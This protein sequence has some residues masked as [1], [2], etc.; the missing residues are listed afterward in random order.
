MTSDNEIDAL[1]LGAYVDGELDPAHTARV[2]AWL[3]LHPEGQARVTAWQQQNVA[4][5]AALDPLLDAPVPRRLTQASSG[6]PRKSI[7]TRWVALRVAAALVLMASGIAVGW[8]LRSPE[9]LGASGGSVIARALDAHVI[10]AAETRHPVEVTSSE[11]DH[12]NA[13][14]S[15]RLGHPIK[16]PDLSPA[17]YRL[18]G[19]R[20]LS[21]GGR[22][23]ALFMY[24][25]G[26]SNRLTLYVTARQPRQETAL[27]VRERDRLRAV[28]WTENELAL[29]VAGDLG[30]DRLRGIGQLVAAS[31]RTTP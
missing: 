5:K 7:S 3:K 2:E 21:D 13:W 11:R 30:S 16:A 1:T 20:L 17:G 19:G 22:A 18:L 29:A 8:M 15:N 26:A 4:L 10:F 6:L 23:V 24:E 14:L 31:V 28:A 9:L 25:D 12:L 27:Q